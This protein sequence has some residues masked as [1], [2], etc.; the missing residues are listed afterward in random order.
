MCLEAIGK[1]FKNLRKLSIS[2]NSIKSW[3]DIEDKS[4]ILDIGS[5][6]QQL[7]LS[8]NYLKT[9]SHQ[10]QDL[11]VLKML[12]LSNNA[13]SEFPK[14][15]LLL[16]SLNTL[17]LQNNQIWVWLEKYHPESTHGLIS[18]LESLDVSNNKL[19]TSVSNEIKHF[20]ALQ[21]LDLSGNKLEQLPMELLKLPTLVE[22]YLHN[23]MIETTPAEVETQLSLSIL[24]LYGNNCKNS[25][26]K[27]QTQAKIIWSNVKTL[28]VDKEGKCK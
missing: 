17:F 3:K 21:T 6:L 27:W 11:L 23:N 2:R 15:L 25:K 18:S 8:F 4:V 9:V 19:V 20:D 12:N 22:F 16:Q 28:E 14:Q 10:V 26:T 7:D 1:T 5:S 24:S 13:I